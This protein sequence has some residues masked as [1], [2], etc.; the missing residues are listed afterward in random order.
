[1]RKM[2]EKSADYRSP[3]AQK[4]TTVFDSST[5]MLVAITVIHIK[6]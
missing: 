4:V 3:V 1:M 5:L 2:A 6:C